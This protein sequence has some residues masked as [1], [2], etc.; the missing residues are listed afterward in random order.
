MSD[1]T[2]IDD[3]VVLGRAAPEPIS[4]GRHTVCLGGY[5]EEVGYVRLYPTQ[6]RMTQCRRWNV[7]SV[8]VEHA[9]PDDHRK[10]SYKIQGSKENWDQLHTKIKKVG[11][12]SKAERIQLVDQLAGDCTGRLNET[13]TSLGMVKPFEIIDYSL[14]ERDDPTYQVTLD[15]RRQEGKNEYPHKLYLTYRCEE[16]AIKG[17]H[18]QHCI[19][20]GI[21]RYWDKYDDPE[22]VCDALKL[23][24]SRYQHY[25][26]VGNLRHQP[27][28]YIV[29]SDLRFSE[30]DMLNA[31]ISVDDQ[32]SL[33]DW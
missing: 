20:W 29:I 25:F 27:T 18:R 24:D 22:G 10:E 8:L 21:Y 12:L 17:P 23:T 2:R 26:F 28:A 7:V 15:G 16:C 33:D 30:K 6:K 14:E 13:H 3:L 11:R 9:K 32:S 5:S 1:T 19:E 4:D 31:G